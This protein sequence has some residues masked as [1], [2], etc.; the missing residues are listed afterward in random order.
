MVPKGA[1]VL[2]YFATFFTFVGFL[3]S[4]NYVVL[5]QA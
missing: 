4:V 3:S 1:V 5:S 2:H